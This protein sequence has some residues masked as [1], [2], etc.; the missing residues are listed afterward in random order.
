MKL[1]YFMLLVMMVGMVGCEKEPTA[2]K[3]QIKRMTAKE[4]EANATRMNKNPQQQDAEK[5]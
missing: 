1:T 4:I 3:V 2:E 5:K